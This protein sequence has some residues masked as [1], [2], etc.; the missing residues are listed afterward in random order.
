MP[1][2]HASSSAREKLLRFSSGVTPAEPF[3][4]T[5]LLHYILM[6]AADLM[7]RGAHGPISFIFMQF[8]AKILTEQ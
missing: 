2:L 4:P 8:S 5:H 1:C 3:R 6:S 7:E